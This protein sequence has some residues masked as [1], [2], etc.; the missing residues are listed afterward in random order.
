[1]R[2]AAALN[3]SSWTDWWWW[4]VR[5]S[6]CAPNDSGWHLQHSSDAPTWFISNEEMQVITR[7]MTRL[8]AKVFRWRRVPGRC[9]GHKSIGQ[10]FIGTI[11]NHWTGIVLH[12][13]KPCHGTMRR[14]GSSYQVMWWGLVNYTWHKSRFGLKLNKQKIRN[15]ILMEIDQSN[16]RKC[17]IC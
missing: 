6:I 4:M 7:V 16:H 17:S 5:K 1:M 11:G 12:L 14:D 10:W 2:V 8:S 13:I 3:C 15:M 9:G